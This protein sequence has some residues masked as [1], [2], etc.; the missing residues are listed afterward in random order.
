MID[1]LCVLV[2]LIYWKWTQSVI[3]ALCEQSV[4]DTLKVN[5]KCDRCKV[6]T[7]MIDILK[8]WIVIQK[9]R[10]CVIDTQNE[11]NMS[12]TLSDESVIDSLNVNVG[13]RYSKRVKCDWYT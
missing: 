5:T 4:I 8:Q 9:T 10:M 11:R 1:A 3:D 12:D 2:W 6:W 13:D 7:R